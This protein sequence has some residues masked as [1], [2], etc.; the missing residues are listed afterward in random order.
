MTPQQLK[1]F[2]VRLDQAEQAADPKAAAAPVLEDLVAAEKVLAEE[3]RTLFRAA[4]VNLLRR[5]ELAEQRVNLEA[6]LMRARALQ[7]GWEGRSVEPVESDDPEL[8][9]RLKQS[10]GVS[11]TMEVDLHRLLEGQKKKPL[12]GKGR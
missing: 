10:S 5:E 1:A 2:Q 12:G 9:A 11:D 8:A 3:E 4:N 6:V 7:T